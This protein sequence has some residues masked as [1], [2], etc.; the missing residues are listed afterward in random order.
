MHQISFQ[1]WLSAMR[2][3]TT[4]NVTKANAE[5]TF[6]FSWEDT[7]QHTWNSLFIHELSF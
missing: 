5:F 2:E 3:I 4:K 6:L 1:F 7:N